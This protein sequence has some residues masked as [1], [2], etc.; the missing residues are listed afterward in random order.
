MTFLEIL[1]I[2]LASSFVAFIL[3]RYIY[4]R[5]KGLPTEECA[6]CKMLKASKNLKKYYYS[7]VKK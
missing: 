6:N 7:Q 4:K 1:V 5:I 3:G 2:I